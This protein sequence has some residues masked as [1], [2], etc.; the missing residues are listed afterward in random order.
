MTSFETG[1]VVLIRFPFSDL[2]SKKKRPA[3]VV[4]PSD[5]QLLHDDVVLLAITSQAQSDESLRIGE[6]EAA[7]LPKPSWVKPNVG[8]FSIE[9]I[10]KRIGALSQEDSKAVQSTFSV[11]LSPRFLSSESERAA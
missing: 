7:G 2:R 4:S 8:T 5:F 9:L 6:W 10:E 11:L 1:D 3:L